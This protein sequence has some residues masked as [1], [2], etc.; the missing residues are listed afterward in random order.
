VLT[1]NPPAPVAAAAQVLV[2]DAEPVYA[3]GVAALLG[4]TPVEL[5][6]PA[7][8]EVG[9][10]LD[11][12]EAAQEGPGEPVP[13]QAVVL[14]DAGLAGV[15]GVTA[16]VRA[17]RARWP[18]AAIVLVM[19][20]ERSE[21][22]LAL[23]EAGARVLLHRRCVPEELDAAVRAAAAGQTWVSAPLA[24]TVRAELL[25]ERSGGR[26]A[27]LS[28]RE[29]EVLRRMATG[30]SNAAIARGLGISENTVRNHVH[31]VLAKL[32]AANRTDAVT[33]AARRGLVEISG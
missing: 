28:P 15:A 11:E 24:G 12:P 18:R 2:V 22:L 5:V 13:S 32:G 33:L 29:R 20:R 10:A 19:R 14:L 7:G 9:G 25:E 23:M 1:P 21:G 17:A 8:W 30:A 3:S 31:A 4:G 27:T 16:L 26:S 6:D